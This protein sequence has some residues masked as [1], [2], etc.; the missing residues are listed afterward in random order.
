G[1]LE[2]VQLTVHHAFDA[3]HSG[4]AAAGVPAQTLREAI[5]EAAASARTELQAFVAA[6]D[7]RSVDTTIR[8]WEGPPVR[9]ILD[10]VDTL[11]PDLV[12][13]GTRG[14]TGLSKLLLGSVAEELLRE[15]GRDV[16]AV[17]ARQPAPQVT[18][19]SATHDQVR[20]E[21]PPADEQPAPKDCRAKALAKP[22]AH[23]HPDPRHDERADGRPGDRQVESPRL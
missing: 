21:Q 6:L 12:V 1:L 20:P 19:G 13:I 7:L 18:S 10:A 5:S 9:S 8:L 11:H 2:G 14:Q 15:L 3:G 17:A 23:P 22:R 4:L 16:L